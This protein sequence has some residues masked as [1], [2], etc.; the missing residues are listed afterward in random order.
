MRATAPA[1]AN[2]TVAYHEA[3]LSVLDEI[4][5]ELKDISARQG[6]SAQQAKVE[7]KTSTR[8]ADITV[9]SY[10][11]S[12]DLAPIG[13]KAMAEFVRVMTVLTATISN[14]ST[15]S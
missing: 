10:E 11:T 2:E 12:G 4:L 7:I 1:P 3:V 14:G 5:A 6:Q 9:A 8:G 13:D 15:A